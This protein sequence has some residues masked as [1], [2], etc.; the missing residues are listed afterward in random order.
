MNFNPSCRWHLSKTQSPKKMTKLSGWNYLKISK[1][2]ILARSGNEIPVQAMISQ[3]LFLI[4]PRNH[5]TGKAWEMRQFLIRKAIQSIVT[6]ILKQVPS[7][8][9]FLKG[10]QVRI[11]HFQI[12]RFR[13]GDG[14]CEDWLSDISYGVLSVG[15]EPDGETDQGTK[16]SNKLRKWVAHW[17]FLTWSYI[18]IET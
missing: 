9:N 2:S 13:F 14:V 3:V 16:L 1:P 10:T 12:L 15:E 6:G 7:N 4:E 5:W 11:C 17:H 18:D 8:Q